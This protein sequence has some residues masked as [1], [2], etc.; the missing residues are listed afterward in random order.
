MEIKFRKKRE[1]VREPVSE[2]YIS[3]GLDIGTT[4][5]VVFVG[6]RVQNSD[7]VEILGQGETISV[8]VQRGQ[9]INIA[10]TVTAIA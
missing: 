7:K 1:E 5:V 9:V 3:V 2:D 10:Q 6:K 4:K 8:G